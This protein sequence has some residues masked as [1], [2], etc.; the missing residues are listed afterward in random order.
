MFVAVDTNVFVRIDLT[1][2]R[3][4]FAALPQYFVDIVNL[5]DNNKL[6]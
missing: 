4:A 2:I 3:I 6:A 1:T 5:D